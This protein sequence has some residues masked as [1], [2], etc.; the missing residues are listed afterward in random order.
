MALG[1]RQTLGACQAFWSGAIALAV[2]ASV[3]AVAN[4]QLAWRP[5]RR[6]SV[7]LDSHGGRVVSARYGVESCTS[8]DAA[9][10][11]DRRLAW[12]ARTGS[13][14]HRARRAN[15]HGLESIAAKA[16]LAGRNRS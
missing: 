10:L 9:G 7:A 5:A 15:R 8:R 14:R 3:L 2:F 11:A 6:L 4:D 16:T 12:S 13:R 1:R